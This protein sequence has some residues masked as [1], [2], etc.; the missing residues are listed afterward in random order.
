MTKKVSSLG[1]VVDFDVLRFKHEMEE[2]KRNPS[3]AIPAGRHSTLDPTKLG[4]GLTP[5]TDFKEGLV[6]MTSDTTDPTDV[7]TSKTKKV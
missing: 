1:E 5:P 6:T 3:V 7:I 2:A 4:M